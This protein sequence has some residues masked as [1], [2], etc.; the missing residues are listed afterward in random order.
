MLEST[1]S[2]AWDEPRSNGQQEALLSAC[3][4]PEPH[5][6][7]TA[8]PSRAHIHSLKNNKE[9]PRSMCESIYA[10]GNSANG[11]IT[12]CNYRQVK[13]QNWINSIRLMKKPL[14]S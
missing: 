4:Q 6:T 13:F 7:L 8:G 10:P 2:N 1:R 3:R 9:M 14:C 12:Q 5:G 11:D